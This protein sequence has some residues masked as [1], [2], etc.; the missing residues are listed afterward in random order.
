M[1]KLLVALTSVVAAATLAGCGDPAGAGG[2]G[3]V[4]QIKIGYPS[5][6]ASYG[7]LYVCQEEGIFAKHGLNV[8]LTLLKTSSQLVAA[9]SSGAVQ[10]AGGDGRAI[11][12]GA[13]QDA[14]LRIIELKLPRYFVEMFGDPAI[15]SVEDLRGKK[16]GVTAPG[17]VTD[18][19]TRIM[20]KD[21]GL[22]DDVEL[23]NLTSLPALIA[24]AKSGEVDAIVTAPPQ[25]VST[26]DQGWHKIT[27]MTNYE[28]AGS[29]YA[30]TGEYAKNQSGTV[31][32]FVKAN[33]ECL[34]YLQKDANRDKSI[35]A[36]QKHTKTEDRE[37]AAYAYDFFKKVWVTDPVVD[38]EIVRE[39]FVEAAGGDP[40]P[41]DIS[42]FI[43]NS[44]VDKLR[45]DGFIDQVSK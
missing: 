8:E 4:A 35:D 37:M 27:D 18:S 33:L 39:A 7:D 5:D 10:I 14:D 21:K 2:D 20:L 40:V 31:D 13:L 19:A 6:T 23:S 25:G 24:A 28:T 26:E 30:V 11:A 1:R 38:E 9:L 15:K 3:D 41:D 17:S 29:V 42:K 43:D 12:T 36:I 45:E 16:V 32:K 22:T 34:A 44:F